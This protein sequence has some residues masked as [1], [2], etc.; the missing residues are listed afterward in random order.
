MKFEVIRGIDN[1]PMMSTT[2]E[3][4]IPY[5]HLQSM[6]EGGYYFRIDGKRVSIKAVRSLHTANTAQL[7]NDSNVAQSDVKHVNTNQMSKRVRCID[8]GEIFKNQSEAAK[9]FNID[10]AQVSDSIKTGRPRSGY[11]FERVI[12]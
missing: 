10:P 12:E 2:Y 4:C 11:T 5:E 6:S 8:T 1:E 3:C 7:C 9:H